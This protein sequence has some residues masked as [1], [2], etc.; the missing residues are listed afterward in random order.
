MVLLEPCG[1]LDL[2]VKAMY[3][4]L[5]GKRGEEGSVAATQLVFLVSLPELL[6]V[7]SPIVSSMKKRSSPIGLRRL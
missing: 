7:Y 1:P 6:E 5:L 2:G 3:V 4:G